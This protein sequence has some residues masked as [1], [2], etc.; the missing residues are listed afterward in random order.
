MT[1]KEEEEEER[2]RRRRKK[3]RKSDWRGEKNGLLNESRCMNWSYDVPVDMALTAGPSGSHFRNP[4]LEHNSHMLLLSTLHSA[5][6]MF[7]D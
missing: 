1:N 2:R 6:Q 4:F 5:V 7:T 3:E